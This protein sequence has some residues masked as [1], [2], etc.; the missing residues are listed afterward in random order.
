MGKKGSRE[1]VISYRCL[2]Y[3]NLFRV[4]ER[5][6]IVRETMENFNARNVSR[7]SFYPRSYKYFSI[8]VEFRFSNRASYD[9]SFFHFLS[10]FF[11][12]WIGDEFDRRK[13]NFF[14]HS[15]KRKKERKQL[16][17][18]VEEEKFLSK[19]DW[20]IM[21]NVNVSTSKLINIVNLK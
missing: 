14:T 2:F 13:K 3:D 12:R 6:G 11:F 16:K 8:Y 7:F 1:R 18:P 4:W 10:M 19:C 21:I 17:Q 9:R 20:V 15:W 5:G